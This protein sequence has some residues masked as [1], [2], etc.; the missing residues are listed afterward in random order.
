MDTCRDMRDRASEAW[1]HAFYGSPFVQAM[2]GLE[3]SDDG[4]RRRPGDDPVH[5]AFVAQRIEDLTQA[6]A[7]G[8]PREAAIRALL[9]ARMPEGVV[10]ERG[11]NLLRRMREEAGGG[12]SLDAF[13]KLVREQ[14]FML[15]LDE[16]RA[17]NAIPA[18][19]A[20]D[21]KS[22][23]R[24]AGILHRV[25][26]AVGLH[27]ELGHMRLAEVD[28]LF[29]LERSIQPTPLEVEALRLGG[30]RQMSSQSAETTKH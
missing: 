21:P 27:T 7:E 28:R 24:M 18:M 6:I 13:K 15:L 12:A 14:F 11:F 29:E 23:S 16:G 2:V 9:Y 22:A 26:D 5:R 1:F 10:D 17:V 3:A 19:L 4:P 25:I 8:G 20:K 30:G